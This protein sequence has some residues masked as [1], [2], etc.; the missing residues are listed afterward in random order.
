M[1]FPRGPDD[2][3]CIAGP[4]SRALVRQD[5]AAPKRFAIQPCEIARTRSFPPGN[6]YGLFSSDPGKQYDMRGDHRPP[7]VGTPVEF[8]RISAQSM[9]KNLLCG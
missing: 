7:F 5:G 4:D 9:E 2:D 1:D 8:E 3:A 6:I